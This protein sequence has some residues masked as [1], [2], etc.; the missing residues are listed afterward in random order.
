MR[1]NKAGDMT[2]LEQELVWII[3]IDRSMLNGK[4]DES[5]QSPGKGQV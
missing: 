4:G 5:H 3:R 1:L 2:A